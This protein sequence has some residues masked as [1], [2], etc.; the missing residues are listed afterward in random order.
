M[1]L[2]PN[3]IDFFIHLDLH[4]GAVIQAYG[5]W[6][7]AILFAVIFCETGLVVT[8]FLPGDSLLFAAGAFAATGSLNPIL[9]FILI[10]AAA[11][12]GNIVNYL[13][14]K[15]IGPRIFCKGKIRFLNNN[16]L[17]RAQNFYEKHGGKTIIITRFFPILR[18]FAPFVAG[19]GQM[20]YWRFI[21]YNIIGGASWVAVFVFGGYCFGNFSFVKNNFF[22]AILAI[23]AISIVPAIIEFIRHRKNKSSPK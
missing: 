17:E 8:P 1:E 18:T 3:L 2:I 4:L 20:N 23:I 12:A 21:I 19:I 14:G 13:I 15:Y 9:L 5:A 16:Y 22:L 11:I 6:T 7:Y 10:S